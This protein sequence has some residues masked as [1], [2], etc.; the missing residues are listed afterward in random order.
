MPTLAIQA[1]GGVAPGINSVISTAARN[2][3][4][5]GFDQVRLIRDG[6]HHLQ[7]GRPED[8][9][10]GPFSDAFLDRLETQAGCALGNLKP[11]IPTTRDDY[12]RILAGYA[13]WGVT[14]VIAIGGDDSIYHMHRLAELAQETGQK[15]LTIAIP[16]TIDNDV[17]MLVDAP[18][19]EQ[20]TTLGFATCARFANLIFLGQQANAEALNRTYGFVAMGR[21][22]GRL[23]Y[24]IARQGQ[25]DLVLTSEFFA[26]R[27]QGNRPTAYFETGFYDLASVILMSR[28]LKELNHP[29]NEPFHHGVVI[30]ENMVDVMLPGTLQQTT[31]RVIDGRAK[32]SDA[33]LAELISAPLSRL[34]DQIGRPSDVFFE[35]M[36]VTARGQT[37]CEVDVKLAKTLTMHAL[38][39]LS[40][41]QGRKVLYQLPNGQLGDLPFTD[42]VGPDA[43]GV[44]RMLPREVVEQ[45]KRELKILRQPDLTNGTV[46]RLADHCGCHIDKLLPIAIRAV[47]T[48]FP[49]R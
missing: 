19:S 48:M 33:P 25:A 5:F 31:M 7:A 42:F 39:L 40:E 14:H 46:E 10:A 28:M 49:N 17:A 4:R 9:I 35:T 15:L 21:H 18:F 23:P 30:G 13:H 43:S 32:L 3:A 11:G 38:Q 26:V 44:V 20:P 47:N 1:T 6:L 8:A 36:G 2:A 27:W 45:A 22:S 41:N 12:A 37:P 16:K 34:L 29:T 24:E